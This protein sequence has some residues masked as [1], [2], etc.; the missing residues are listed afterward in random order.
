MSAAIAYFAV[1]AMLAVIVV[2]TPECAGASK[3]MRCLAA[4]LAL[5]IWPVVLTWIAVK[6]LAG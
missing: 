5:A 2:T 6:R 4:I 3:G 1:G